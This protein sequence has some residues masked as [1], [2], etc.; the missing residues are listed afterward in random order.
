M[1][2]YNNYQLDNSQVQWNEELDGILPKGWIEETD[3]GRALFKQA[4]INESKTFRSLTDWSE[5]VAYEIAKL[6][7]LPAARYELATVID[8]EREIFGSISVDCSAAPGEKRYPIEAVLADELD[9]Y[10]FPDDYSIANTIAALESAN[11]QLP[12]HYQLPPGIKDGSVG[13]VG[14]VM[15][16]CLI[17]N[18]DRHDRNL[19][20]VVGEDGKYIQTFRGN[21]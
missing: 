11:V 6:L 12:P 18:G 13:F 20:V 5:K 4:S 8:G 7:Q 1:T 16:D 3:F 9:E 2:N 21:L 10:N 19:E 14:I 17:G 15:F